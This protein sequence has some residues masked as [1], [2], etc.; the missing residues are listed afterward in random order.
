MSDAAISPVMMLIIALVILAVV[1]V[2]VY[3]FFGTDGKFYNI[4][5]NLWDNGITQQAP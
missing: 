4:F 5:A 1:A 3:L 2:F